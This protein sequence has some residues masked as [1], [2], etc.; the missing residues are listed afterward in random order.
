[1]IDTTMFPSDIHEGI[2][3]RYS[4]LNRELAFRT[5][6]E[7]CR[8]VM[9]EALLAS[10]LGLSPEEAARTADIYLSSSL[11]FGQ[12]MDA[13]EGGEVALSEVIDQ[14]LEGLNEQ[15][16]WSYLR[17]LW[18]VS[19]LVGG[20]AVGAMPEELDGPDATSIIPELE[21]GLAVEVQIGDIRD[22]IVDI[23]RDDAVPSACWAAEA[24]FLRD[25]VAVTG[26]DAPKTLAR[27]ALSLTRDKQDAALF[28]CAVHLETASQVPASADPMAEAARVAAAVMAG[29]AQADGCRR[30]ATGELD[31]IEA[32]A[33][34]ERIA[35][36][37]QAVMA[38]ALRA[39]I[40][41]LGFAA[42][43]GVV[44]GILGAAAMASS[45]AMFVAITAGVA[46]ALWFDDMGRECAELA[47]E[48]LTRLAARAE[49]SARAGIKRLQARVGAGQSACFEPVVASRHTA[50]VAA[51]AAL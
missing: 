48:D 24:A 35:R 49:R 30:V 16:Q 26:S 12:V 23:C 33:H 4:A 44:A 39:V 1:M 43:A 40:D 46:G 3:E 28:A 37:V 7:A 20:T 38:Q 11:T 9:C 21:A 51:P 25:V 45:A 34:T 47:V 8:E 5:G 15:E 14:A 27:Q 41:A 42:F 13:P 19:T 22:A 18:A 6:D 32:A 31:E 10:D 50:S 36:A 17:A 29:I 2:V